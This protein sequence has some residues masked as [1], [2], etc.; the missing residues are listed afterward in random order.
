VPERS[1]DRQSREQFREF[2]RIIAAAVGELRSE[3]VRSSFAALSLEELADQ[4]IDRL[5]A[6]QDPL[7][8]S[9]L[10]RLRKVQSDLTNSIEA[11]K[12]T[13]PASFRRRDPDNDANTPVE[14]EGE[15]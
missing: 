5:K 6:S 13:S 15:E 1:P 2:R 12:E 7:R 10:Q 11:M 4:H 3:E 14:P 8:P 9:R